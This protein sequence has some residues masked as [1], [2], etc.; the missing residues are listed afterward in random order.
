M[1][2]TVWKGYI[3]FGLVSIPVRLFVAV[4]DEHI[5]FNQ[6]HSVCNTRVRQQ[7]YCPTCDRVVERSEIAKGYQISKDNY[8][9]V[10]DEEIKKIAPPSSETMEIQQFVKLAD[11]D[12]MYFDASYYM[13][14]EEPGR[15]AYQL[16]FTTMKNL[17]FVALAQVAMHQR[18]YAVALRPHGN[19][20]MLHTMFYAKEVR[21]L[22]EYGNQA[23][24]ELKQPEVQMAEQLINA[25]AKPFEPDKFQDQYQKKLLE[26][27][28]A[29]GEG[30]VIK[31][32]PAKHM[33]PVIDLMQALQNSL[34]AAKQSSPAPEPAKKQ[35]GKA[36]KLKPVPISPRKKAAR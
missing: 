30:R 33:A 31:G 18:E 25:L 4:R 13:V 27:V 20:L 22:P 3:A 32:A 12:P 16:L 34:S 8:V 1:A 7:L 23:D 24:V 6:I 11:I 21:E 19:G 5:G 35:P 26:L 9:L 10:E 15:R 29:K 17:D 2:S 28:E 14:P 36:E